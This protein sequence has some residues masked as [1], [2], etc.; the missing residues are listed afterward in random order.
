MGFVV[1]G[2]RHVG[3]GGRLR[4]VVR[5]SFTS[6]VKTPE[7]GTT[8]LDVNDVDVKTRPPLLDRRLPYGAMG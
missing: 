7:P 5:V 8:K 1:F 3:G 2:V 6:S 4:G